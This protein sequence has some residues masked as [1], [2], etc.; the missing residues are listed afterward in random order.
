M[1]NVEDKSTF[2]KEV[3]MKPTLNHGDSCSRWW[4]QAAT[5]MFVLFDLIGGR[6]NKTCYVHMFFLCF[7]NDIHWYLYFY[8]FNSN[9]I[10]KQVR[11]LGFITW[12]AWLSLSC[13]ATFLQFKLLFIG[14]LLKL[15]WNSEIIL[16]IQTN[17]LLAKLNIPY[18]TFFQTVHF[19]LGLHDYR[20]LPV[21]PN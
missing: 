3:L 21:F 13:Q 14:C 18:S 12:C 11:V 9:L 5:D 16:L 7:L 1:C 20:L 15:E 17:N 10:K 6:R 8:L 19:V 2:V 4:L